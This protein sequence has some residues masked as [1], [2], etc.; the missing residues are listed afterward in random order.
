VLLAPNDRP[1]LLAAEEIVEELLDLWR[2]DL[3]VDRE[4]NV[5]DRGVEQG[6]TGWR[7]V[8][9]RW[10]DPEAPPQYA[11]VFLTAGSLGV[12]EELAYTAASAPIAKP[13]EQPSEP[14]LVAE[15]MSE[16]PLDMS[17]ILADRVT[18]ETYEKLLAEVGSPTP[19]GMDANQVHVVR[20]LID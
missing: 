12:A 14:D 5:D 4:G 18:P 1:D 6:I 2:L 13:D 20:W 11:E 17:M 3:N 7:M 16:P 9:R 15:L 19:P 10:D 8:I